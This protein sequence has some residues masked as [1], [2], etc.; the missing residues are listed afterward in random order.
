NI[1]NDHDGIGMGGG[2][3]YFN[4]NV[5]GSEFGTAQYPDVNDGENITLTF[6]LF[7]S[8]IEDTSNLWIYI[9]C[10]EADTLGDDFVGE[11]NFTLFVPLDISS[12]VA[13]YGNDEFFVVTNT[14]A[15]FYLYVEVDDTVVVPPEIDETPYI[16]I[17]LMSATIHDK[18]EAIGK[19]NGEIYFSY[20]IYDTKRSTV[21][22]DDV[23]DAE[24]VYP[25]LDIYEGFI[26]DDE[27]ELTLECYEADIDND[28]V[29][30]GV[31]FLYPVFSAEWY[32]N[33]YGASHTKVI[34][35][36]DVTFNIYFL[37]TY[38]ALPDLYEIVAMDDDATI[39]FV[40][41]RDAEVTVKYGTNPASLIN[42]VPVAG[43]NLIHSVTLTNLNPLTTYYFE[44]ETINTDG[45]GFVDD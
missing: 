21:E 45:E 10:R 6:V 2:E 35:I 13:T 23:E 20:E 17:T 44:V 9:E 15:T 31:S 30:G 42:E 41:S 12:F 43:Y 5:N 25:N 18:H 8:L 28:D 3:I 19:G 1:I 37:V 26:F 27:L 40:T 14:D 24:I 22:I 32:R 36:S 38:P 7:D 16:L 4:F 39:N 33:T 29:L 34:T 11:Y